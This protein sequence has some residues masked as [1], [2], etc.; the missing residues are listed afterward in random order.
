MPAGTLEFAEQPLFVTAKHEMR[1][2]MGAVTHAVDH[3]RA[4]QREIGGVRSVGSADCSET[5][6]ATVA[7]SEVPARD[8]F[9]I[10]VIKRCEDLISS[11]EALLETD[12]ES[13]RKEFQAEPS[14]AAV[15]TTRRISQAL[16]PHMALSTTIRW[17]PWVEEDGAVSILIHSAATNRRATVRVQ[18]S[19]HRIELIK[20]DEFVRCN[21][22]EENASNLGFLQG[23]ARWL[24]QAS[25]GNHARTDKGEVTLD[26]ALAGMIGT[27]AA[28]GSSS[29]TGRQFSALLARRP[30]SPRRS[31]NS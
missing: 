28:G 31:G 19:G 24:T 8:H 2:W 6:H 7:P 27:I 22:C 23:L 17:K 16:A 15:Q 29:D 25:T 11:L 21:S 9:R 4:P 12:I 1:D 5:E 30:N 3:D 10:Y 18:S 20:I 14:V 13:F 26:R